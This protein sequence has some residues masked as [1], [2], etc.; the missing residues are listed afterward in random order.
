MI[1]KKGYI[2]IVDDN[3]TNDKAPLNHDQLEMLIVSK[4]RPDNYDRRSS[5][6]NLIN[7]AVRFKSDSDNDFSKAIIIDISQT[8]VLIGL[9][10]AI[11]TN[12]QFTLML[13]E[14][15]KYEGPIE[16]H[17]EVIRLDKSL[18]DDCY[19]YGCKIMEINGF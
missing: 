8:G 4:N 7:G 10:R 19:T 11:D 9:D 18:G 13:E 15:E 1:T 3:T 5:T 12:T 2:P 16:I 6:R 14:D 17:A